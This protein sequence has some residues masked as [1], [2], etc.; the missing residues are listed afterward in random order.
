MT[1]PDSGSIY[2]GAWSLAEMETK[3]DDHDPQQII[4]QLWDYGHFQNPDMPTGVCERDLPR[5]TLD[6]PAVRTALDSYR[7]MMDLPFTVNSTGEV[8]RELVGAVMM[9]RCGCPDYPKVA[10]AVDEVVGDSLTGRGSW[11]ANC[12]PDYPGRHTFTVQFDFRGL[13]SFLGNP[14]DPNS[15]FARA[16]HLC[17]A[18]Y[19]D[20]GIMFVVQQNNRAN[21]LV[22]W[23][24]GNGWLG[25]AI[26]GR[27]QQC[28]SRIWAKYDNRYNPASP[29]TQWKQLFKHEFGHNMGFGHL[30]GG[31]MNAS[32]TRGNDSLTS[33]RGDPGERQMRAWFGG[34]PIPLEP[35]PGP[36]PG[37]GGRF[38]WRGAKIA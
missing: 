37:P 8:D 10:M 26:V 36:G 16:W 6:S 5:L 33:W 3:A 25:L 11:P 20:M 30:R 15:V 32:L 22:T 2:D 34:L 12:H 38:D 1:A 4:R 24:R 14:E 31:V 28:G 19:A 21:T 27:G 9:P 23:Q 17:R 18:A 13:P 29:V 35:G 7:D